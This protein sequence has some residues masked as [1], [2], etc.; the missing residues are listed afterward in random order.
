MP[1][2]YGPP[3]LNTP[4]QLFEKLKRDRLRYKK[5]GKVQPDHIFNFFVTAWHLTDWVW[6]EHLRDDTALRARIGLT[7]HSLTGFQN[8]VVDGRD[9]LKRCYLM[10]TGGK[11]HTRTQERKFTATVDVSAN[12]SS[13]P[14]DTI[15][16]KLEQ[17]DKPSGVSAARR[18]FSDEMDEIVKFWD[19]FFRTYI[20]GLAI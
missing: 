15:I 13:G 11:H 7:E 16:Y 18:P 4:K 17:I 20:S 19:W 2:P 10:A 12:R 8:W 3:G 14:S 6:W 5:G 9:V 1:T